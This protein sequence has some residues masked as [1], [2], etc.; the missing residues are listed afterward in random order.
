[1]DLLVP[2]MRNTCY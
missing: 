1:V 2:T